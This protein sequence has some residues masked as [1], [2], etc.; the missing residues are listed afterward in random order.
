MNVTAVNNG[1]NA[2]SMSATTVLKVFPKPR[3]S[4]VKPKIGPLRG[5]NIITIYGSHFGSKYSRGFDS[6]I[7]EDISV[8]VEGSKCMNTSFISDDELSCTTPAGAG[9]SVVSV[10]ISDGQLTRSGHLEDGY[11]HSL[12]Y[13]GGSLSNPSSS[14]FVAYSPRV[15]GD[16]HP[17][18]GAFDLVASKSVRALKIFQGILYVGG[19]FVGLGVDD[20]R[21]VLAWD[22][23][24]IA[25][26]EGGVDGSVLCLLDF[27]NRLVVAGAFTHVLKHSG[28]VRTGCLTLWDGQQWTET[29]LGAVV[30]GAV[31]ALATN[32]TVLYVAG[33]FKNIGSLQA[34]GMAMWNGSVWL[35]LQDVQFSGDITALAASSSLLYVAGKF[36]AP[37]NENDES[38]RVLLWE[39]KTAHWTSLGDIQGRVNSLLAI[40]EYLYVGGDFTMAGYVPVANL[41][42]F[43][44]SRWETV[45]EGLNGAVHALLH[46][47]VCLYIGGEFT[48]V[49]QAAPT[50]KE[51]VPAMF[52]ARYCKASGQERRIEGLEPFPGMGF[53]YALTP[54]TSQT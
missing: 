1:A 5:G 42:V 47:N 32:G 12:V 38:S 7:Y 22:G 2:S 9:K 36:R 39:G 41:A 33:R 52:S 6:R 43:H 28:S 49:Y 23:L 29:A 46:S 8:F 25:K 3:V 54:A 26:L 20:T 16:N 14:G 30:D 40:A 10:N 21:F 27:Q 13:A 31:T 45:A 17:S 51:E 44:G 19:D 48:A 4:A 37:T 35:S 50:G 18:L 34:D 15:V 53:V 24:K 11:V